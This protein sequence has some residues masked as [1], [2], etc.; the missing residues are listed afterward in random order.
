MDPFAARWLDE[1]RLRVERTLR[2]NLHATYQLAD[3]AGVVRVGANDRRVRQETDLLSAL[4]SSDVP[5]LTV[6]DTATDGVTTVMHSAWLDG[7]HAPVGEAF[8]RSVAALHAYAYPGTLPLWDPLG[9]IRAA[10][11]GERHERYAELVA[12]VTPMLDTL[13]LPASCRPDSVVHGDLH[14]CNTLRD[15]AGVVHLIDFERVSSG[16]AEWDCALVWVAT[17]RMGDGDWPAFVD[18][19]GDPALATWTADTPWV[20]LA[21]VHAFTW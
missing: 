2:V 12:T 11:A 5:A 10:L 13:V 20:A 1:R 7:T 9:Q 19:Y 8:A 15:E 6:I 3:G 16:P 14:P 18:A 4:S 17:N 21:L